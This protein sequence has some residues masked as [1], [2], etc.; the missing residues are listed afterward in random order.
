MFV[1]PNAEGQEH[2]MLRNKTCALLG[3]ITG[4]LQFRNI[5]DETGMKV[6]TRRVKVKSA[7]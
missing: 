7:I 5:T 6:K 2:S 3:A 4:V 1:F